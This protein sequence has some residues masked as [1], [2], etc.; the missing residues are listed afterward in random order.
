MA[1]SCGVP[2]RSTPPSPTY[3]PSVFSRMTTKSCGSVWPG[4]VPTN[5]RWLTYRSSSK[6]IFSSSPRSITPGRHLGR[7]DRAEQDGVEAAQL[8]ERRVAE[9]L[10]VAQVARRRRGRSRSSR[11]RRRRRATTLSASAVTSGPMP[12]P[13]ITAIRCVPW[14]ADSVRRRRVRRRTAPSD[15]RAGLGRLVHRWQRPSSPGRLRPPAGRVRRPHHPRPHRGRREDRARP[16]LLGDLSENGDYHAAKDEQ[17]HMEG[18]IRQLEHILENAEIIE[19]R[20]AEACVGPGTHRHHRLRGRQRRHA[21]RYLVGH[22]EEKTDGLDVS[23][24][25]RRSARRCSAQAPATSVEY[26]APNG[27]LRGQGPRGG[28]GLTEAATATTSSWRRRRPLATLPAAGA[29]ATSSCPAAAR[30]SCAS[31][32]GPPGAPTVRAAARLDGDAPT[33]T[34]S[35]CYEPLGRA[36]PR[37][38]LRPPRPRPRHPQPA[39]RSGSR[40]APTTPSRVCDVLGIDRVIPVGYSMGGAVAQLMWRRHPERVARP[41]AVRHRRPT[42][43]T[44]RDERLGVPRAH[45]PRRARPADPGAGARAG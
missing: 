33:S 42:S 9:D 34:G 7:A 3:G 6:R 31:S 21:E 12:S 18:R 17:G 24:R 10:A 37:A 38:R 43:R 28:V 41:R 14:P 30:R 36:L 11:C 23:A 25:R 29:G 8:V 39:A 16:A 15:A 45:R 35:R 20:R 4:A 5:G 32:P 40:T 44:S 22:I 26:E 2:L 1:T 27:E 19:A 13:P